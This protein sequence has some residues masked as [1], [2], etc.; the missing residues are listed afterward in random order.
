MGKVRA[1]YADVIKGRATRMR[2]EG[3]S[4]REQALKLNAARFVGL[5]IKR[6]VESNSS[7]RGSIKV[8]SKGYL[9]TS[10]LL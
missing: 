9:K 4:L 10:A 3:L 8:R 7:I 6:R 1:D 2:G 5:L